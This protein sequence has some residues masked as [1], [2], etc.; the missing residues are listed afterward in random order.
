MLLSDPFDIKDHEYD[1]VNRPIN[2]KTFYR[3]YMSKSL[4][5]VF[6]KEA[7]SEPLYKNISAAH[8]KGEV[9]EVL[10]KRFMMKLGIMGLQPFPIMVTKISRA[11]GKS[12]KFHG[13]KS[14]KLKSI[15]KLKS[16]MI[17]K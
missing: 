3:K 6:R 4:P 5:C 8:T 15:I 13:Q 12:G 9:D 17:I 16:K 1:Q 11:F 14:E 2:G 10:K 7:R